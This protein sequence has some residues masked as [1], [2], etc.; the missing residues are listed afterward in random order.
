MQEHSP[1]SPSVPCLSQQLRHTWPQCTALLWRPLWW[2]ADGM[3]WCSPAL[4]ATR[5]R[6]NPGCIKLPIRAFWCSPC[7]QGWALRPP[8]SSARPGLPGADLLLAAKLA[9][10]PPSGCT[11]EVLAEARDTA[12]EVLSRSWAAE[13]DSPLMRECRRLKAVGVSAAAQ[14]VGRGIRTA[15]PPLSGCAQEA[16]PT[17]RQQYWRPAWLA[18]RDIPWRLTLQCGWGLPRLSG[19]SWTALG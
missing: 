1:Q 3:L 2:V 11:G 6:S 8:S 7:F 9:P 18:W 5:D 10:P 12:S 19:A 16:A 15:G 13:G 17:Q 14:V 4:A